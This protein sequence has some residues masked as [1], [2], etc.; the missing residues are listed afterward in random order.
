MKAAKAEEILKRIIRNQDKIFHDICELRNHK[1]KEYD[2]LK[3][4]DDERSY[5]DESYRECMK[6]RNILADYMQMYIGRRIVDEIKR[7]AR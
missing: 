2:V 4:N 3:I 6:S 1:S 7:G 5:L